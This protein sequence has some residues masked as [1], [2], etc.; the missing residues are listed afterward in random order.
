MDMKTLKC[1]PLF[2]CKMHCSTN[3]SLFDTF[4]L[5]YLIKKPHKDRAL[6]STKYGFTWFNLATAY[7]IYFLF[8]VPASCICPTTNVPEEILQFGKIL[9]MDVKHHQRRPALV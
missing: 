5:I 9:R 1:Q 4:I 2:I 3:R 7:N 8:Y 6:L